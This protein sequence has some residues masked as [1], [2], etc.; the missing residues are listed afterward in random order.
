MPPRGGNLRLLQNSCSSHRFKSCPREGA[1]AGVIM[2]TEIKG[3]VSSHAPARGQHVR[4]G[5]FKQPKDSFKSCP[6]EGA[7]HNG[8]DFNCGI[9]V[10]SHAPAR[11]QHRTAL[12]LADC[13]RRVSSHAPARGQHRPKSKSRLFRGGFKSCPREGA[14]YICDEYG[15]SMTVSSHAPARG[16]PSSG[17]GV[18]TH[19]RRVSSHAPARG[20]HS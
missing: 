13:Q 12:Q 8:Q 4:T 18:Q 16:Q 14:T 20:Q 5:N 19:Y 7:T 17:Q 10:S 6:R 15:V 3:S 2:I 11:G 1:T 9:K